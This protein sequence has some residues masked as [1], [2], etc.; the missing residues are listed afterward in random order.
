MIILTMHALKRIKQ[1][2]IKKEAITSAILY[3]VEKFYNDA[4]VY[5]LKKSETQKLF[6]REGIDIRKYGGLKVVMG[7]ENQIVTAYRCE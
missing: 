1:R 6:K 4:I 7:L 2:G 3:G 5:I